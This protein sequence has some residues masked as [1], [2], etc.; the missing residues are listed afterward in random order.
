[1]GESSRQSARSLR[2][3]D[4]LLL[5][6]RCLLL[7]L[8]A[9]ILAGP[10]WSSLNE[11]SANKGWILIEKENL[12]ES[13]QRF[14]PEIDSLIRIGYEFHF[15]DPGFKNAK[16]KDALEE[17]SIAG[18]ADQLSYW[19]LIRM[20]DQEIPRNTRAYIFTPNRLSRLNGERPT[21]SK[22]LNWK[23]YT[24]ADSV[25]ERIEQAWFTPSDSVRALI[26]S[27]KPDGTTYRSVTADPAA[28]NSQFAV[29][30]QNGRAELDF[31]DT[32][33]VSKR[34][35]RKPVYIDSAIIKIALYTDKFHN[36]ALYLKAAIGAIRKYTGR[37]ILLSEF[38]AK[39]IPRGQ[40]MIFWLSEK[41]ISPSQMGLEPGGTLF[42]YESGKVEYLNS[43][44]DLSPTLLK[45]QTNEVALY[46]R[47]GLPQKAKNSFT[48]WQDGFGQPVLDMSIENS[49]S[50]YRFYSRFD[51]DWS[52]LV[53]SDD[54]TKALTQIILPVNDPAESNGFDRR[55]ADQSQIIPAFSKVNNE[56]EKKDKDGK[57][58][59]KDQFW[60][61]L[62]AVFLLERYL[63]FRQNQI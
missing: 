23:T 57:R 25:S 42:V 38:S 56:P 9:L 13:Y 46:K 52:D 55:M 27:S 22:Q 20:L 44:L 47:I 19:S 45:V 6:L 3:L 26:A 24:P 60:T 28:R 63:S 12:R 53:W 48:F 59:P 31:K 35:G 30:I 37:K 2:L 54:F 16:I 51:P 18:N 1:M 4:L 33:T 11:K 36:D 14:K 29:T 8:L 39:Q 7:I 5:L 50:V 58:D 15:F 32:F 49:I 17:Q 62:V 43:R 41:K 10:V 40:N 34:S 61:A 21:I